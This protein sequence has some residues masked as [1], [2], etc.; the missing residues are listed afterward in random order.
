MAR[1]T[2]TLPYAVFTIL[3][4]L[5]LSS[6]ASAKANGT[7]TRNGTYTKPAWTHTQPYTKPTI[8]QT[9]APITTDTPTETASSTGQEPTESVVTAGVPLSY[10]GTGT[11]LFGALAVGVLV[12]LGLELGL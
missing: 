4:L 2:T 11:S 10:S 3:L 5:F 1:L 12:G 7:D 6:L 8:T 9:T